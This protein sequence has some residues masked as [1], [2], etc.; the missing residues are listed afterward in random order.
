M[1]A[2]SSGHVSVPARQPAASGGLRSRVSDLHK[3]NLIA[4][5]LLRQDALDDLL[6][7]LADQLG[8]GLALDDCVIYLRQGETLVQA[9]AFGPKNPT[10]RQIANPIVLSLGEGI[11][12][13][14][15]RT[16]ASMLIRDTADDAVYV[17]DVLDGRSELAVP[18][19]HA[20]EVLGVIDSESREPGAYSEA[21]RGFV[22]RVA[23]MAAPRIAIAIAEAMRREA[24]ERRVRQLETAWRQTHGGEPPVDAAPP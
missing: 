16:G 5:A 10:A 8:T 9:A 14:V 23:D 2:S 24:L 19:I 11:T 12:G 17:A 18:L 13:M 21:D 4:A 7:T 1:N 15:A 22:Q 20:G 6:W 3:I